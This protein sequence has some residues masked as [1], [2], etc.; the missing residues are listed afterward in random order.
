MWESFE[1]AVG[2]EWAYCGWA[3]A[4][5]GNEVEMEGGDWDHNCVYKEL[6]IVFYHLKSIYLFKIYL[7]LYLFLLFSLRYENLFL[8]FLINIINYYNIYY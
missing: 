8:K 6:R 4:V 3:L 2:W 1:F 7:L 5:D